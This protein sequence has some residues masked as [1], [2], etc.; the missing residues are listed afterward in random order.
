M[1]LIKRLTA[2]ALACLLLCP[3]ALAQTAGQFPTLSLGVKGEE[4]TRLQARLIETGFLGGQPDGLFGKGTQQGVIRLQNALIQQ[5][6]S[7]QADGVAGPKTLSLLYDD[8]AMQPFLD[9][10]LGAAG[11]RVTAL[12]NRLIDLKFLSDRADGSYGENTRQA[13]LAFQQ[14]LIAGGAR[15]IQANGVADTRTRDYLSPGANLATYQLEAPEFFDK[16]KPLSLNANFL[17]AQAAILV[18]G[19]TGEVLFAKN[20]NQRLYPAST[21]KV[22]TLMLAVQRGQLD[23]KVKVPEAAGQVAKDSSLVPV[24]PGEELPYRDLLYGLMIRS[25]NDAANALAVLHSGSVPAFVDRMNGWAQGLGLSNTHFTN[26]HGYHDENH[27][28]TARDLV[29]LTMTAL[30]DKTVYQ[31]AT[32]TSHAMAPSSLRDAMLI[33]TSNELLRPGH[34]KYYEGALGIKSGYTSHAGF[35]YVGMAHKG[36]EAVFAVILNCRTRSRAWDDM[37]RLFDYGFARLQ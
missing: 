33:E 4:V 5:G 23:Q 9:L 24:T 27:Y 7:L 3:L 16:T 21:T 13:V 2:I 20:E 14:K 18:N 30:R 32:A 8:V 29:T 11:Q 12:Q 22:V 6:H 25:G 34:A 10:S 35:C 37:A 15:D 31:I 26:P 1:R 19:R 28:T 17:N 36:Q